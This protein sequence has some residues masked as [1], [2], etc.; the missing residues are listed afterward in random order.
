[1]KHYKA[2]LEEHKFKKLVKSYGFEI[3]SASKHHKII[4]LND[5]KTLM[6]FAIYH[7]KTGK[8][9]V[10]PIYINLFFKKIQESEA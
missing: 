9:E 6:N 7:S 4:S 3:I 10:K 2:P 1:M 8:R 5:G